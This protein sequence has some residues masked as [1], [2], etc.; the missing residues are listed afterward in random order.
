M[1]DFWFKAIPCYIDASAKENSNY[2]KI[3][4]KLSEFK[5]ISAPK[6]ELNFPQIIIT[7]KKDIE[8]YA[9]FDATIFI[10]EEDSLNL[11]D[12]IEM[13]YQ[14]NV[15]EL[16]RQ[17][18]WS[19]FRQ[20]IYFLYDDLVSSQHNSNIK[21]TSKSLR[22]IS[23][24]LKIQQDQFYTSAVMPRDLRELLILFIE[25][26]ETVFSS[27]NFEQAKTELQSFL[28]NNRI[29]GN[30]KF[31]SC[32]EVTERVISEY[33]YFFPLTVEDQTNYFIAFKDVE[34]KWED[35]FIYKIYSLYFEYLNKYTQEQKY[36]LG[37]TLNVWEEVFSA[38]PRPL[39]LFNNKGDLVKHNAHFINLGIL[40]Q[41]CF[42]L[43]NAQ[44]I[45]LDSKT[46]EVHQN[47]LTI[48]G[49]NY[50]IILFNS[51]SSM[52]D[53]ELMPTNEELGIVTGS[54]AHELNNP[55]AGVLAA[56]EVL[57]LEDQLKDEQLADLK[58]IR[59]GTLR[60]KKLVE[61]FLGFSRAKPDNFINSR[62]M[63]ERTQNN[64]SSISSAFEQA[65][66]LIR[67][68]LIENNIKLVHRYAVDKEYVEQV[69][70]S[71][72]AMI[73]Y[74]LFGELITLFSHYQ[75]ISE[76]DFART[77]TLDML[78]KSYSLIIKVEDNFL[79]ERLV[80]NSKLIGHLINLENHTLN[81]SENT[82]TI[83][84]S[85]QLLL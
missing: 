67:F 2:L 80:E 30:I 3:K 29:I 76:K 50:S 57:F 85:T 62:L 36:D 47:D 12:N 9:E 38:F 22:Y 60:C 82:L 55:L 83:T 56:V 69:N 10:L 78:E 75:L 65:L 32:F 28:D 71:I 79:D 1:K 5:A 63:F 81:I 77:I 34:S 6:K 66:D 16:D 54:I 7:A 74:L 59:K 37:D 21:R 61:T 11:F 27:V 44:K 20:L 40:A 42:K 8:E 15:W 17:L 49:E 46:F 48:D 58:E 26:E 14:D 39:A 31:Y 53:K 72:F 13:E 68:R 18:G 43:E 84:P 45:T 25:L 19:Q 52:S 35:V 73:F 70:G 23:K 41:D 4:D 64:N 24:K 51:T 33:D